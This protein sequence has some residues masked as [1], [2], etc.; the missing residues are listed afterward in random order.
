MTTNPSA[1][2]A[3]TFENKPLRIVTDESGTPWFNAGD[4][5]A[6]LEY[7]NPWDAISKH[8][9]SEDLAKREAL[10][11]GGKQLTNHI[12]ESGLYSLIFGSTKPEA[13]RFKRW[14]TSEVLPSIRK[15]GTYTTPKAT[16]RTPSQHDITSAVIRASYMIGKVPGIRPEILAAATLEA[17]G[18]NT[19]LDVMAL[20]KALPSR[21]EPMAS[22]T[23]T[24]I[25]EALGGMS[26]KAVNKKLS[27]MGL[28]FKNAANEWELTKAGCEFG[29]A[30]PYS[31]NGH[32]GYQVSWYPK[33][34]DLFRG[35]QS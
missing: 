35:E 24:K 4:V 32:A 27:E 21:E 14:V 26:A 5:C 19:G 34:V 18:A 23:P 29:E 25:G 15:T 28:Q 7:V 10:T 1:L 22:L 30:L 13:K 2:Q 12:N 33:V 8:V 31:R 9:D 16:A 17:I 3:F 6:V 11:A 20:R